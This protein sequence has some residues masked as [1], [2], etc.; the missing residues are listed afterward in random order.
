MSVVTA[1]TLQYDLSEEEDLARA[2]DAWLRSHGRVWSL[3][4]DFLEPDINASG[5][6]KHPQIRLHC[7]GLNH[8]DMWVEVVEFFRA[9]DW[10]H[11]ESAVLV[12]QPEEGAAEVYRASNRDTVIN[13]YYSRYGK[14]P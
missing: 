6:G 11:P 12:L 10:C 3:G 7:A 2:L 9:L 1:L 4:D 14:R 5:G 8:F 13:G